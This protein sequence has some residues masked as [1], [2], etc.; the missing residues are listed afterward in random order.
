MYFMSDG[1]LSYRRVRDLD[2]VGAE[3][4]TEGYCQTMPLVGTQDAYRQEMRRV[5]RDSETGI[6]FPDIIFGLEKRDHRG[7]EDWIAEPVL[8]T[9]LWIHLGELRAASEVS[10]CDLLLLDAHKFSSVISANPSAF[11]LTKKYAERF[12][13]WINEASHDEL[14]DICPGDDDFA[15]ERITKKFLVLDTE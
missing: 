3:L 11:R 5:S 9:T 10:G 4:T 15:R 13:Q 1:Q 12:V 8:W 2:T 6:N 14:S 7:S